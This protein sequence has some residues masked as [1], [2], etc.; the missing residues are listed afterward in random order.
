MDDP[1]KDIAKVVQWVDQNVA[2]YKGDPGRAFLWAQSAGN[3]PAGTYVG[4]PELYGPKGVGVKGVIFMSPA[5][6]NILPAAPPRTGPNPPCG[7]L[8]GSATAA[9]TSACCWSRALDAAGRGDA[10]GSI[11]SAGPQ[12]LKGAVPGLSRR[13]RSARVSSRSPRH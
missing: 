2:R 6:F 11:E 8:A 12:Q 3:V 10:I 1:A 7:P 13:T 9:G 5:T 4:H